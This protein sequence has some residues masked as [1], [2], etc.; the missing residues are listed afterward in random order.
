[1]ERKGGPHLEPVL[2]TALRQFNQAADRLGLRDDLR[3]MLMSFKTIYQTQFPVDLDDGTIRIFEGYRV[4]H[5]AARGPM[6]G[7]MRYAPMVSVDEMKALAMWMTWKCAVVNIPFGGAKGGVVCSPNELSRPELE[8]LTR[9][10]T[11]EI[12]PIIGPD[13][14]IPAPDMGTNPQTMAWI[15]DTY[16]MEKGFTVPGVVTG[17]PLA[18]GGSAGRF[19]AT[20]RGLLYVLE[21]HFRTQGGLAGR[22]ASVQGF[23]NVGSAVANFLSQAGVSVCYLSDVSAALHNPRGI[24][25]ASALRHRNAGG[26]LRTWLEGH[27][28]AAEEVA[29]EDVLLAPV[30]ILVPAAVESVLTEENAPDVRAGLIIEGA[31]GPATADA[32]QILFERGVPIIPD[33]LANAGGVTVSYFEWVQGRQYLQWSAERVNAELQRVMTHSY[34]EVINRFESEGDRSHSMRQ[35]AQAIAIGRVVEAI[36]LRGVFP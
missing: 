23:G 9:R 35:A 11:S 27:P 22:T 25:A 13:R 33:T 17:K 7:G 10:F 24:D 8:D 20:G 29:A 1:M 2:E 12:S 21:E 5:N 36:E 32:D 26:T 6:K 34:R 30:D 28:G 14:D 4:H 3:D 31:N 19:E 15:M 16:S 18:L